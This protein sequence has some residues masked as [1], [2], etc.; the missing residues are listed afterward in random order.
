MLVWKSKRRT[1]PGSRRRDPEPIP[2]SRAAR[3]VAWRGASL[4]V[5]ARPCTTSRVA[6][7][8][9]AVLAVAWA[10]PDGAV[11]DHGA[12]SRRGLLPAGDGEQHRAPQR[13]GTV[14]EDR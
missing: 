14:P 1:R 6:G 11:G 2:S 8:L 9:F 12:P 7:T 10:Q 5:L 13:C 3:S 4:P